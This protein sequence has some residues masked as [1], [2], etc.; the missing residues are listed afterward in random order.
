MN[1]TSNPNGVP[2]PSSLLRTL[3][4]ALLLGLT[5]APTQVALAQG[6]LELPTSS[7]SVKKIGPNS[8]LA[9]LFQ[10]PQNA[11]GCLHSYGTSLS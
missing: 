9:R 6:K 5:L 11:R 4:L 10:Y 3:S 1:R 2:K 8:P 7:N